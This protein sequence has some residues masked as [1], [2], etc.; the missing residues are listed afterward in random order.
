[1]N[2][3][4]GKTKTL[5]AI[6]MAGAWIM[7]A[8]IAGARTAHATDMFDYGDTEVTA[9]GLVSP[10]IGGASGVGSGFGAGLGLVHVPQNLLDTNRVAFRVNGG[11][12]FYQT[13][14]SVPPFNVIPLTVGMQYG[15][16]HFEDDYHNF[17]CALAD[18]GYAVGSESA[19][20][21]DAGLGIQ[22]DHF[23]AELRFMYLFN[24]V[25]FQAGGAIHTMPFM[26]A[27]LIVG[28]DF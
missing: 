26:D 9:W 20:V 11:D 27:P 12:I 25:P 18:V 21:M 15:I 5:S 19:P 23:F 14:G 1:M 24:N 28:L 4:T 13:N 2:K 22:A 3:I 17:V 10:N 6:I 7:L 16:F 8:I